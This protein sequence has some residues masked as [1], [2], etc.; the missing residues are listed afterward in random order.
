MKNFIFFVL[1]GIFL[2]ACSPYSN[3]I[4][5]EY[6][7]Q[8]YTQAYKTLQ[9]ATQSQ[10]NDWLLWKMQSGFLTFGYFGAHFS[11]Y[12]LES[13]EKQ[14]KIYEGKGL[15]SNIG[16]NVS[17]TLSNDMA[18]PYRG[19]IFEGALLNFYKALAFSSIGDNTQARIEFNRANDRQRRAKEYYHKE[20]QKAHDNAV[21][22]ANDKSKS[23]LYENNTTDSNINA[24]LNAQY[25]NLKQFAVYKDMINPLI[26]YVSGLYFMIEQ[27]FTKSVDLLKEA[28]GIS[29]AP[30][31]AKD[32][33][34]LE[35]RKGKREYPKFTWFIIE[36][37]DMARTDG[38]VTSLPFAI[39]S[40]VNAINL[41]LPIL[42]DG[43]P[44]YTSYRINNEEANMVSSISNLFASEFEKQLPAIITRAMIGA[45][46]KFSITQSINEFGGDYGTIIGLASMIAFS[47]TTIADTRTSLVLPHNVWIVR[48]PNTESSLHIYG[49]NVALFEIPITNDCNTKAMRLASKESFDSLIKAKPKDLSARI[50]LFKNYYESGNENKLC[51]SSDNIV[52]MR[53]HRG[54]ISHTI[55]KGE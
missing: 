52:Y 33:Q 40:G 53:V 30:I 22:A 28:Y 12:D 35:S 18:M 20:I 9:K 49:N 3:Q 50:E 36:D 34:L 31:V 55:I 2:C 25:T 1:I 42:L 27:D 8:R 6:D 14:F 4:T 41:A 24:I 32:M 48:I 11:L 19:L 26:P 44:T 47:A 17:S 45:L 39:G 29:K 43:K 13:A 15:L 7:T 51:A 37:G 16:A 10:S 46:V 38:F 21:K 5:S 23:D 54:T